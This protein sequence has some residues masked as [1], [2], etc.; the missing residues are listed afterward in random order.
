MSIPDLKQ[1]STADLDGLLEA[2]SLER[3]KREPPVTM[4]QPQTMEAALDPKWY[5]SLTGANTI[6]QLRHPGFGWVGYVF[7]P[8][9]RA[10]LATFLLQHA[11]M[12]PAPAT[13]P[14]NAPPP[15]ASSGGGSVH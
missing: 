10:A 5:V 8:P 7:P 15:V 12:P 3:A 4:E 6:L 11:L 9:S 2:V 13:P 14:P 1:M